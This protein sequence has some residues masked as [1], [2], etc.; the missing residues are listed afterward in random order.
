MP[1]SLSRS[2]TR[3]HKHTNKRFKSLRPVRPEWLGEKPSVLPSSLCPNLGPLGA[4]WRRLVALTF[5]VL[6]NTALRCRPVNQRLPI[7]QARC[8]AK[9]V[10]IG[11]NSGGADA[12]PAKPHHRLAHGDSLVHPKGGKVPTPHRSALG[13]ACG[14]TS[15]STARRWAAEQ[16]LPRPA[17]RICDVLWTAVWVGA[18]SW[19]LRTSNAFRSSSDKGTNWLGGCLAPFAG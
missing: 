16:R 7:I 19:V 12:A 2:H 8:C 3:T 6:E 5:A 13:R 11:K 14:R 10:H 18:S 1:P 9:V 4:P 17:S 15:D